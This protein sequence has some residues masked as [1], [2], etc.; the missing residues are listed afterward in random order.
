[1]CSNKHLGRVAVVILNYN[2]D[3]HLKR[4]M[5]SIVEHTPSTVEIIVAD[6]GSTDHSLSTLRD[7]FPMVRI[8]ELGTNYGYAEGYNRALNEV[9]QEYTVLINSDV[10]LCEGWL[11]PLV[12]AMDN[13]PGT[14]AVSPK[15][16]SVEAP[17]MFEYAGGAGGY[18]DILGY[19]FCRGRI[20]STVE[21]DLGQYNSSRDIFW[22]SGAAMICRTAIFKDLGGF[23]PHFFAHMEE[24]DLCWRM[25]LAGYSVRSEPSSKIYH[26]GGGTLA[27][28]SPFK[29]ELNHRNNIAMLIRC[30]PL[31]QLLLVIALRPW[32]DLLAAFSYLLHCNFKGFAAPFRAYWRLIK[33]LP[34]LLRER[35]QI[36]GS[37]LLSDSTLIFK[38]LVIVE[39]LLGRRRFSDLRL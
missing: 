6:N 26:L 36:R 31:T 29:I 37:A 2:G 30:A 3:N 10:Q 27:A 5:R 17:T 35:S 12:R 18:I 14:A 33:W 13:D 39:Y 25:Q 22:S 21:T 20:L 15:I 28:N 8:I 24:I 16:L 4:F 23:A 38:R 9:K 1:M 7:I 11:E 19:P 32:L 34:R